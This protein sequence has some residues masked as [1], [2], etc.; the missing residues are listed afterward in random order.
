[1]FAILEG[2]A[3]APGQRPTGGV[4]YLLALERAVAAMLPSRQSQEGLLE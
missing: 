1:L 4:P 2:E 3:I